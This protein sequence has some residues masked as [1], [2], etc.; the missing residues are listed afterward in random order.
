MSKVKISVITVT[1]NSEKTLERTIESIIHQGY[2]N[3]EYIIVDGGS[4]DGTL[5]IIK[6]YEKYITK[7]IS[8][9]DSGI[10]NAF[11]KGIKMATG[12][13]I[14]IINSDDG[15]LP[16]ALETIN[17]EYDNS[18]DVYRGKVLLWKEDTDTKVIEKPS[19]HFSFCGMDNISH[20]S[21]F[22]TKKAYEKYGNYNEMC[23]YVMDYDLL[24]RFEREGAK[25]KY[26]DK[27]LAFYSLGG[28]TF[29][30]YTK[31]RRIETELVM[32]SNGATNLDIFMF[33][34]A[35]CAKIAV[36]KVIPKE[37]LMKIKN[38]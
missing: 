14:G 26:I 15:L 19:M 37:I 24:L 6:K 1:F 18:V 23:K 16:E 36:G 31:T 22:I 9:P 38:R 35:K 11:N 20:Q 28:I 12:E 4:T 27:T 33:R 10:S 30:K 7:W 2:D 34:I 13:I 21:T 17:N 29:S 8:E 25:Y 3:L 32:R 5:N